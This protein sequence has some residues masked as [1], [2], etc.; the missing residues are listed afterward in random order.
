[1]IFEKNTKRQHSSKFYDEI[2]FT[3][4]NSCSLFCFLSCTYFF[5]K[6]L[7]WAISVIVTFKDFAK[8]S[9]FKLL[10]ITVNI[11]TLWNDTQ[12]ISNPMV[13]PESYRRVPERRIWWVWDG[14]C[15]T[16]TCGDGNATPG[17]VWLLSVPSGSHCAYS[18]PEWL[19]CRTSRCPFACAESRSSLGLK[20]QYSTKVPLLY[21]ESSYCW[22]NL[23]KCTSI[24]KR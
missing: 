7:P 13:S 23:L 6:K 10:L 15:C 24:S 12:N 14:L 2:C 3:W 20:V 18:R 19:T 11:L 21:S 8:N 1:M 4:E 5:I 16:Q 17:A 9:F 22:I